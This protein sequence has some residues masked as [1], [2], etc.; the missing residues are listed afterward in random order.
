MNEAGARL[1][2][3]PQTS[4]GGAGADITVVTGTEGEPWLTKPWVA[5]LTPGHA[6]PL[7]E[8]PPGAQTVSKAC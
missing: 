7:G 8:E 5:F 2:P 6:L 3:R 1:L 4:G